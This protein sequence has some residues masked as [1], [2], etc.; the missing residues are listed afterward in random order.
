MNA[1]CRAGSVPW[2]L[3]FSFGRALQ[4]SVIKTWK[5]VRENVDVAQQ[6]LHHR[7]YCN[8]S[9][10]QGKYFAQMENVSS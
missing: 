8:S 3:S 6:V 5:G 2:T 9:A 10:I 1:I 4:A 7:A